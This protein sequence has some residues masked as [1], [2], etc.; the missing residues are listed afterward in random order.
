MWFLLQ[1]FEQQMLQTSRSEITASCHF[2][3]LASSRACCGFKMWICLWRKESTWGDKDPFWSFLLL[4]QLQLH[5]F[6][7]SLFFSFWY[8]APFRIC[9]VEISHFPTPP[10][11][12]KHHLLRVPCSAARKCILDLDGGLPSVNDQTECQ[13]NPPV[14]VPKTRGFWCQ[15]WITSFEKNP[16]NPSLAYQ[17]DSK[18]LFAHLP[19]RKLMHRPACPAALGT[20]LSCRVSISLREEGTNVPRDSQQRKQAEVPKVQL[21]P[22]W[23]QVKCLRD[24]WS[25]Q[26]VRPGP[27]PVKIQ[28][29]PLL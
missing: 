22:I 23:F 7:E 13:S 14:W 18:T 16:R 8:V 19:Q 28:L 26:R 27:G 3:C 29:K 4:T 15:L 10:F 17:K 1:C 2:C 6:L 20:D 21:R 9:F 25:P 11:F 5:K 24:R 12:R